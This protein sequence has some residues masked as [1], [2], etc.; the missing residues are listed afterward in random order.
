M[1]QPP[2]GP[3]R[4]DNVTKSSCTLSWRPPKDDGGSDI[5]HYIVEKVDMEN[6][7]WVPVADV[8]G[9]NTRVDHLIEGHDYNFRVRAVNKQGES[10]PLMGQSPITAKDPFSKPDKP[11]A[12]EVKGKQAVLGLL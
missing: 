12:P 10:L 1:P 6:M 11:G 3:L 4:A 5:S 8:T 7:R 2:E 9:L